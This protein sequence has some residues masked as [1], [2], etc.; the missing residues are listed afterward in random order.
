MKFIQKE[1]TQEML[2]IEVC[3]VSRTEMI[4]LAKEIIQ[5]I[6]II[7]NNSASATR[8]FSEASARWILSGEKDTIKT[9]HK[10]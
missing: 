8:V 4:S 7:D 2:L 3:G 1:K 10:T 5:A 9:T 6:S